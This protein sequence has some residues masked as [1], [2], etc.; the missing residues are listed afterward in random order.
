MGGDEIN[1][2]LLNKDI[3]NNYGWPISSYGEHYGG[4]EIE[5]NKINYEEAPLFKSHLE[6]GFI[7]P[8][9]YFTPSI[10][11]SEIKKIPQSFNSKFKNDFFIGSMG[12]DTIEGDLSIHHIRL[13]NN[14]DTII[15][16]Q[17]ITLNE[18]IRDIIYIEE[19]NKVIL[20]L[21][22]SASIGILN[23]K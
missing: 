15:Y 21:E 19:I 20:F 22:N 12:F 23:I 10:S 3:P 2:N 16:H 4:K 13:N 17:I 11:I 5:F 18:R 14:N 8:I 6:H 7:E 9:K 1:L